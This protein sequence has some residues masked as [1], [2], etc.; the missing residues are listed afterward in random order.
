MSTYLRLVLLLRSFDLIKYY[1]RA[2]IGRVYSS[3]GVD[4]L[5]YVEVQNVPA[6]CRQFSHY[7]GCQPS[8]AEHEEY[9]C[10]KWYV[11]NNSTLPPA[12]CLDMIV[13][14]FWA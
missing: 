10:P 13:Q 3:V 9:M 11:S 14:M 6:E 8:S 7:E 1:L 5:F 2:I 12:I 4:Y